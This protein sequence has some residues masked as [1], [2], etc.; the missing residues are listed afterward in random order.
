[1][2]RLL[3]L[4]VVLAAMGGA[5]YYLGYETGHAAGLART[6]AGSVE[7]LK[8]S[9]L[10]RLKGVEVRFQDKDGNITIPKVR[11]DEVKRDAAQS[12]P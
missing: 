2:I 7:E 1:M 3:L 10:D 6:R 12:A 9:Y 5:G 11:W 4:L 8:Q